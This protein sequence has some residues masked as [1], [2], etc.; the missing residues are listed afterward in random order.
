MCCAVPVMRMLPPSRLLP[1]SRRDH[2]NQWPLARD[3][4]PAPCCA[5]GAVPV[6]VVVVPPLVWRGLGVALRRVLPLLLA[7]EC[8][9]VEVAP[10]APHRLVATAVDEVG[11]KHPMLIADERIG[12]VPL[13]D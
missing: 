3:P 4:L 1:P 7:P 2:P 11:A 5:S 6:R 8:G 12:A 13:V 9:D 10:G